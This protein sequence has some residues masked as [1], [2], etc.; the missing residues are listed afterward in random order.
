MESVQRKMQE[1]S[2]TGFSAVVGFASTLVLD[3]VEFAGGMLFATSYAL[4]GKNPGEGYS[5]F[6]N[7]VVNP[8]RN[9]IEE[10]IPDKQA[11]NV[12]EIAGNVVEIFEAGKGIYKI[13]TKGIPQIKNIVNMFPEGGN[14][15]TAVLSKTLAIVG[16]VAES[17]TTVG[18]VAGGTAAEVTFAGKLGENIQEFSASGNGGNKNN[19]YGE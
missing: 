5:L 12:G 18:V 17:V 13:A 2:D 14:G 15:G 9:L 10:N 19:E 7:R 6:S 1:T 3:T 4:Q 8:V 11:Y 16:E